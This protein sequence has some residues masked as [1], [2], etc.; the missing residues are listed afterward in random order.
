[1]NAL[2]DTRKRFSLRLRRVG[3]LLAVAAALSLAAC[4]SSSSSGSGTA[5]STSSSASGSGLSAADQAGLA[6]A[7]AIVASEVQQPTTITDTV[8]VTKPIPAG[9]TVDFIP[10]GSPECTLEGNI[11]K[12]AA[13][14][15]GW[16][17]VILSNDGTPQGDKAAFGQAVRNKAAAVL[18]TAIPAS[19]FASYLPA[20]KANGTFVSACC[21]TDPVGPSTGIGYVIDGPAQV[22]PVGGTQA[23]WIATDSKDKA[24][25]V[26]VNIPA[27][28]ILASQ[29]TY[30]K[31]GMAAYCPTCTSSEIDIALANLSSAPA[32]IVSYLRAHPSVNYVV[33]STDAITIGLPQAIKAAGLSNVKIVGQGATPTNIQYLHSGQQAADVAFPYYEVMYAM[34]NAA[35][36]DKAGM[37]VAASVAPPKW[38]LIP[39]NAPQTTATVFPVVAGYQAQYEALWGK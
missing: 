3:V 12:Q 18:Y 5:S 6:K 16:K 21:V 7:Q 13:A 34:V 35:I 27:F 10:C 19:T 9:L 22:G 36:Q 15:V 33:A 30:F 17:T 26:F 32:T 11:V 24:N 29:A 25:A 39:A 8:K 38:L 20:L 4:S 28:A 37:P 2:D 23:A 31:A 14:A 1:M